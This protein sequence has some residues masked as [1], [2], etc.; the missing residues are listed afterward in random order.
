MDDQSNQNYFTLWL[1]GLWW[2]KK[3]GVLRV[4]VNPIPED[5]VI[6]KAKETVWN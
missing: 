4:K 1:K 5:Q 2:K 3:K 6:F